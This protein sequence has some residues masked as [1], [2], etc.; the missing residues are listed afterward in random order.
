MVGDTGIEPVTPSMSTKCSTAEL[1]ALIC[2]PKRPWR[3]IQTNR[4]GKTRASPRVYRRLLSGAQGA[5]GAR[6][7]P[8]SAAEEVTRDAQPGLRDFHAEPALDE[9][10]VFASPHSGRDYGRAFLRR[11]MLDEMTIRS[12]EDAFVDLLFSDAPAHGARLMAA[13]A[14]RAF[15]DLNRSADELDPALI[16]G[17]KRGAHNPRVSAGLGVIPRVVAGGREIYRGKLPL[18]DVEARLQDHWFPYHAK[19][20]TLLDESR[21]AVRQC[22]AGGLPF[23]AA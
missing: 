12:S 23:D 7:W 20:Q 6:D 11:S 14:P 5:F 10:G 22:A 9:R 16:R 17:V 21:R 8:Y 18:A 4:R 19:L 15:V 3:A 13:R 1:I 2:L